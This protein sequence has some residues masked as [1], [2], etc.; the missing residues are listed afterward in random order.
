MPINNNGQ[1]LKA[2]CKIPAF[3]FNFII[4]KSSDLLYNENGEFCIRKAI[5]TG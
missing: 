4:L 1:T 5:D 2:G 3:V